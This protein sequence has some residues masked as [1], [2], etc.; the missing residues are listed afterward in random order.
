MEA[1]ISGWLALFLCIFLHGANLFSCYPTKGA[2]PCNEDICKLPDCFCS[3]TSIPGGLSPKDVP[4]MVMI[5]FDDAVNI[6]NFPIYEQLLNNGAT[7]K[8]NP[9]GKFYRKYFLTYKAV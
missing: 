3:G 5:S 1:A 2:L 4:Q 6:V 7:A 8:R 9:N